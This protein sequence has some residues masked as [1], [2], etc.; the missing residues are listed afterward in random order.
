MN[1]GT[2]CMMPWAAAKCSAPKTANG[3]AKQRLARATI[4]S[5]PSARTTSFF[6]AS[7]AITKN[8]TA[9]EQVETTVRE[10]SKKIHPGRV[11]RV[12]AYIFMKAD[13]TWSH[14]IRRGAV[15]KDKT[16]SARWHP[17]SR[18]SKDF[19]PVMP[20]PSKANPLSFARQGTDSRQSMIRKWRGHNIHLTTISYSH[21]GSVPESGNPTGPLKVILRSLTTAAAA[22]SPPLATAHQPRTHAV[23][24]RIFVP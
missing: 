17:I 1:L 19:A 24:F 4:L 5:R 6:A 13:L 20:A 7:T 14:W 22:N 23:F 2:I 11:L 8:T 9:A 16:V 15:A 10:I 18:V 3:R 12:I 21:R